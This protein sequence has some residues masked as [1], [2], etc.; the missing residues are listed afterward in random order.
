MPESSTNEK[1]AGHTDKVGAG[2]DTDLSCLRLGLEQPLRG[3]RRAHGA[4]EA[5][6][7][8]SR[9]SQ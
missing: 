2:A 4:S 7:R 8:R 1:G 9:D 3:P 5:L 6:V